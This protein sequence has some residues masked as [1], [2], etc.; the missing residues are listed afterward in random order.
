MPNRRE[1]LKACLTAPWM[2][3]ANEIFAQSARGQK[4]LTIENIR[5]IG[6]SPRPGYSWV[7]IKVITSEPGLYGLG[8]AN[9]RYLS[10]AVKAALEKH[11]LPFWKGKP[12]D[13]IEDMWQ[14]NHQR[15]YWLPTHPRQGRLE[16]EAPSRRS[17]TSHTGERC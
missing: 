9:Y 16:S 6:T 10:W 15:S 1:L 8:S 14:W 12:A 11:M 3:R 17:R 7:F 5:V 13:R 2:L 4:P